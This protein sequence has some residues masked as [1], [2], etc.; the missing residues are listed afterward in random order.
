MSV[1]IFVVYK[2]SVDFHLM[3]AAIWISQRVTVQ[4][5]DW[6]DLILK[7]LVE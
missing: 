4:E 2:F 6:N 7:H 3:Y 5:K 1:L